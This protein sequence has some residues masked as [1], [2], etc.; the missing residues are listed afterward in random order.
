MISEFK[1]PSQSILSIPL[2][3]VLVFSGTV[4]VITFT[5]TKQWLI[6]QNK[7]SSKFNWKTIIG[8]RLIW[9]MPQW[10]STR[11]MW[12]PWSVVLIN[13]KRDPFHFSYQFFFKSVWAEFNLY[14]ILR[15]IVLILLG[16]L[17]SCNSNLLTICSRPYPEPL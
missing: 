16:I 5:D 15:N 8:E 3:D 10:W 4:C 17:K 1:V 2:M 12:I 14:Y 6:Q 7:K 9:S 13:I 11:F